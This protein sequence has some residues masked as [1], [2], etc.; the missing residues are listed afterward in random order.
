MEWPPLRASR[1]YSINAGQSGATT[2]QIRLCTEEILST[3]RPAVVV[4]QGG[5]NDLK[6]IGLFPG[7]TTEIQAQCVSN[8]VEIVNLCHK[9]RAKVLLTLVLPPGKVT[10]ARRLVW[11]EQIEP[12]VHEVNKALARQF[13]G[14]G[15]VVVLDLEQALA[16]NQS[17]MHGFN[18]YRDT[19]HMTPRAYSKLED[20]LV[21]LLEQLLAPPS[22]TDEQGKGARQ[23]TPQE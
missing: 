1:F 15:E 21:D 19:L 8:I 3:V 14:A 13:A 12:A 18:V 23:S 4:F 10:L 5:I 11:S 2:A 9:H 22:K 6:A 17:T 16:A 7:A 20:R